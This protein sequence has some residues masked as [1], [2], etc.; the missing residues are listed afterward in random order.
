[1][2]SSSSYLMALEIYVVSTT[3]T[4]LLQDKSWIAFYFCRAAEIIYL[5][6]L[7]K[8]DDD[9]PPRCRVVALPFCGVL[10]RGK[11]RM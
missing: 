10:P 9:W 6:H 3:L 11:S 5:N 7:R 8:Q 4:D 2:L 1:M